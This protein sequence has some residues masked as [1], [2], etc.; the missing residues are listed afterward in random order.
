MP[1]ANID[2]AIAFHNMKEAREFIGLIC[3]IYP[4]QDKLGFHVVKVKTEVHYY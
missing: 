1:L 2:E 3:S 4:R